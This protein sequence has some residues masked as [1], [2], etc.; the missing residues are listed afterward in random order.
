M[1]LGL[2]QCLKIGEDE[3]EC[4]RSIA[5]DLRAKGFPALCRLV[6][7]KTTHWQCKVEAGWILGAP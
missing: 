2:V 4:S 1:R 6:V 7:S 3:E 5:L